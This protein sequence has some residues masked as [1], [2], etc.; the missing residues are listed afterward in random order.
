M[1]EIVFECEKLCYLH[2]ARARTERKILSLQNL[3]PGNPKEF[4]LCNGENSLSRCACNRKRT[5]RSAWGYAMIDYQQRK[6]C[7][8]VATAAF[9]IMLIGSPLPGQ[10]QSGELRLSSMPAIPI[11]QGEFDRI[12]EYTLFDQTLPSGKHPVWVYYQSGEKIV[13]VDMP[14]MSMCVVT[15]DSGADLGVIASKEYDVIPRDLQGWDFALQIWSA[16]FQRYMIVRHTA[17]LLAC[18]R[19]RRASTLTS[20]VVNRP[21]RDP[22]QCIDLAHAM[23]LNV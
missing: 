15:S 1:P 6:A 10:A 16:A 12:F 2:A 11:A 21:T 23:S 9:T 8:S 3:K 20:I 13:R 22:R 19:P 5:R 18:D 17:V 4:V 14:S 7:S